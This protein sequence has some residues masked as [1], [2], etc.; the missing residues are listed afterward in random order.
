MALVNRHGPCWGLTLFRWKQRRAELWYCPRNYVIE[1]HSHSN[2]DIELMYLMG[3]TVF[4]RRDRR[5]NV[6][7]WKR[8]TWRMFGRSF[9]VK[10]Y[11]SHWFTVGKLPL[12][13]INFQHFLPGAKPRSA[14]QDFTIT[15]IK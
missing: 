4:Y 14:A 7:E 9:S 12:L 13:F 15:T 6:Q 1:E 2:E 5:T 3:S 11:H 8:M 10:H